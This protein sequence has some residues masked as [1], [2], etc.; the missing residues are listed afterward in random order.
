[1]IRPGDPEVLAAQLRALTRPSEGEP[2][3]APFPALDS[4]ASFMAAAA[5]DARVALAFAPIYATGLPA[6]GSAL[7][8]RMASCKE[9]A[10]S[11]AR[12]RP[13]TWYL[14]LQIDEPITR[15]AA[16]FED[17]IHYREPIS[18]WFESELASLI[19]KPPAQ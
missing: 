17:V 18:R 1:M 5:P 12:G 4:L 3:S 6:E 13:G 2:V 15:D 7:A 11:L 10:Q 14:D 8:A 19:A 9:R 16:N